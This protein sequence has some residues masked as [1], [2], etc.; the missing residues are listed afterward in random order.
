MYNNPK[1]KCDNTK[2]G[3]RLPTKEEWLYIANEA[4]STEYDYSGSNDIDSVAWYR[5]NSDGKTHPVGGKNPN[6]L[7]IYDMSGN[8]A[9]FLE[10]GHKSGGCY[11]DSESYC[12]IRTIEYDMTEISPKYG[13]RMVRNAQ[14]SAQ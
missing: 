5:G 2:N 13:F 7:G 4:N 11:S 14:P 9:E 12:K 1:I 10:D 3:Y 8:V 6:S